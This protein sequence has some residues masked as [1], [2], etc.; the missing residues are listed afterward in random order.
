VSVTVSTFADALAEAKSDTSQISLL[1]GNGFSQA[2]S[3]KFGYQRLRDVAAMDDK[4]TSTV[5]QDQ[6][7]EHAES[8]DFETVIQHLEQSAHLIQL[9]DATDSSLAAAL[10]A[11]AQVV[12]DGLVDALTRIHPDSARTVDD[13][14]YIAVRGF[15]RNFANIFTLNY[16]LLLYWAVNQDRLQPP[17]V[18]S[19]GFR[20]PEGVLTWRYPERDDDQ[21]LFFL[22][23]AMHLYT[24]GGDIRKLT[25]ADGNIVDQLRSNLDQGRY[26]L[27]VT[28]GS[29]G[30]KEARIAQV[31]YLAFGY[32]RLARLTGA[33]FVHGVAFS[34]N[35]QHILDAIS[36]QPGRI[37]ALYVGLFGGHSPD[38]NA[39]QIAA[40][41][42]A[43]ACDA[44]SGAMPRLTFYQ[45]ES[46]SVWG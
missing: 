12:K 44:K 20:R 32:R 45:S 2:F 35:D 6:L 17:V 29:R 19:D 11:D 23:G 15:L 41:Q 25:A 36:D 37:Q 10:I 5:T 27:V 14:K 22:H 18:R 9:Y 13:A 46:A 42:L 34:R 40:E 3:G 38:R 28:E 8:D 7:F 39:V 4:L 16:D 33:L 31:P 43:E 1:L 21:A 30:N 26:P 24:D